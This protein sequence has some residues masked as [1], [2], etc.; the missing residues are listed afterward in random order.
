MGTNT[1]TCEIS[2]DELASLAAFFDRPG[3][4]YTSYPT[5]VQFSDSF[6]GRDYFDHLRRAAGRLGEPLAIYVHLPF[7]ERR[8]T[9]CA[10]EVIPT[11]KRHVVDEYLAHLQMEIRLVAGVLGER[12][13]VRVLHLGGGTP[14]FLRPAD[15]EK[16]FNVLRTRFRFV[17]DCEISVELDPR[18][19]TAEHIQ[20]LKALGA[21]RVSLGV[22]DIDP[23]VQEAIGRF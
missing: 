22:Q 5:A 11:R 20:T 7:C 15:L 14:T 1:T 9:Y 2:P 17:E 16:L 18:V 19:T 8:C 21:N 6:K 23:A 13:G 12:N 3:P 4:R 10:C